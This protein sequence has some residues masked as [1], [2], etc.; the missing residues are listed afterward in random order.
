MPTRMSSSAHDSEGD[1]SARKLTR[2]EYLALVTSR[3]RI[4]RVDR[5]PDHVLQ[6]VDAETG[7]RFWIREGEIFP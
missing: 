5:D 7:E 6:L 1:P 2:D 4:V 3:R